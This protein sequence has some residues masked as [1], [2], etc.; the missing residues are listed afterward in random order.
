MRWYGFQHY[1]P[2][3]SFPLLTIPPRP[4]TLLGFRYSASAHL[5]YWYTEHTSREHLPILFIHGIGVGLHFYLS[6]LANYKASLQKL[7]IGLIAVELLP[8]SSHMSSPLP[9]PMTTA[10]GIHQILNSHGWD[11]VVLASHSYGSVIATWLL[12]NPEFASMIGPLLF[13]DPVAFSFHAPAVPWNFLRRKP[14]TASEWQ[15]WYFASTDPDVAA[16]LTRRFDW[17][18]NSLWREDVIDRKRIGQSDQLRTNGPAWS[19]TVVLAG[20][21]I[22]TDVENLGAY[23]TTDSSRSAGGRLAYN[24]NWKSQDWRGDGLE[25]I[26]R[27]E[28]NHAEAFDG[29]DDRKVLLKILENYAKSGA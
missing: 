21:D 24:R 22:I 1:T 13:V 5:S 9:S 7:G 20:R 11:R 17:V 3:F 29:A 10:M 28:L 16:T 27:E 25:I 4:L 15:L 23:L 19:C 8:I 12:R 2:S 6:F 26:W 14:R 18:A